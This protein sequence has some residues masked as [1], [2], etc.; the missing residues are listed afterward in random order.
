MSASPELR[1]M[2]AKADV[3]L[4]ETARIEGSVLIPMQEIA[5]RLAGFNA[6]QR[7]DA[8]RIRRA[9]LLSEPPDPNA[10][11]MSDKGTINRRA[12]ID[13]RADQVERLFADQPDADVIVLG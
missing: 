7:G 4:I 8:S 11:E 12:V 5:E 1:V 10:H 2:T 13:R 9:L 3:I 6:G